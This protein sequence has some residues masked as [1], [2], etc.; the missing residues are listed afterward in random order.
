MDIE[1]LA[2]NDVTEKEH[3]ESSESAEKSQ[4]PQQ[5]NPENPDQQKLPKPVENQ[6]LEP[7]EQEEQPGIKDQPPVSEDV[8]VREEKGRNA[9]Q[10]TK[11]SATKDRSDS[12][13]IMIS[14]DGG[15]MIRFLIIFMKF[16][17]HYD[18][19]RINV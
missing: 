18:E 19:T 1:V 6:N 2:D 14:R 4:E 12:E 5:E 16:L 15:K 8:E 9:T 11:T 10:T 13:I 7:S 3:P 17:S